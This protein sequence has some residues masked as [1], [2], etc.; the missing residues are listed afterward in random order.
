MSRPTDLSDQDREDIKADLEIVEEEASSPQQ[1]PQRV[2]AVLR[3]LQAAVIGGA[4][5]GAEAGTKDEVIQLIDGAQRA[6]TGG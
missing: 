5:A 2:R 6:I 3:R 4:P 1:R